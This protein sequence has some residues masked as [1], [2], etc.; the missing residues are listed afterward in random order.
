MQGAVVEVARRGDH[1]LVQVPGE[2]AATYFASDADLFWGNTDDAD[3]RFDRDA[4]GRVSALTL[5]VGSTGAYR[6]GCAASCDRQGDIRPKPH[7]KSAL[8]IG[9]SS[10][11]GR[12]LGGRPDGRDARSNTVCRR[13]GPAIDVHCERLWIVAESAR[14][15][16]RWPAG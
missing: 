10:G 13:A 7:M 8:V 3:L 2:G 12:A 1:L 14:G 16:A 6:A 4:A 15:G 9:A 11:I 5:R